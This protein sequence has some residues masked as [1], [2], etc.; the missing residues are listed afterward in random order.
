MSRTKRLGALVICV[1]T[2]AATG[3]EAPARLGAPSSA[4]TL[5]DASSANKALSCNKA[6]SLGSRTAVYRMGRTSA[7]S[8]HPKRKVI[9][10][11]RSIGPLKLGSAR[12][13]QVKSWAGSPQYKWRGKNVGS[14]ALP[15]APVNFSGELW[16]Y[17]CPG[18]KN[19]WPCMTLYGFKGDRLKTFS[20]ESTQFSTRRGTH[21]G[22]ALSKVVKLEHGVWRG[23]EFQCP[24]VELATSRG[25]A[26]VAQIQKGRVSRFYLSTSREVFSACGS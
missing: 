15:D 24:S 21:V 5:A 7:L 16:G 9:I 19:G 2:V 11:S 22:S 6:V 3:S 10:T 23:Y 20:T 12:R 4:A 1:A 18:S 8:S 17:R 26:S 14:G 25:W 13:S